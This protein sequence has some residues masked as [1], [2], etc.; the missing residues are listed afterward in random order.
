VRRAT[1]MSCRGKSRGIVLSL[2]ESNLP[3]E[4]RTDYSADRAPTKPKAGHHSSEVVRNRTTVLILI[5][6]RKKRNN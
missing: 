4:I 2:R 3:Q 5:V 1:V 6:L